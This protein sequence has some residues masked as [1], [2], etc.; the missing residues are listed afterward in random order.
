MS[1][2]TLGVDVEVS[3]CFIDWQKVFDRVNWKKLTQ[4]LKDNCIEWREI[5]YESEC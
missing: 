2:L 4:I 1:E 5:V 3:A